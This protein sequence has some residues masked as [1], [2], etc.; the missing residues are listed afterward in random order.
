VA[1]P[2]RQPS[3][4]V[5][6]LGAMMGGVLEAC[7]L[8]PLDVVKT[9]LQLS[10]SSLSAL[11]RTMY[12]TE[13]PLSFYKG[14]TPFVTHLVTKYSVRWYFNEFYRGL[15]ADKNGKVSTA[16][17]FLAGTGAGITEAVLIVT[18]FE[19]IKTRLQQQ[20]GS[21]KSTFKYHG[22]IQTAQTIAK[23]EGVTALWKGNVPTMLRQGINQL[24]LFGTY[25][26]LKKLVFG[27]E[28]DSI[29]SSYQSLLL[30]IIAGALGPL[31]NNPID[32]AKTRLMAQISVP[33]VEPKY[34]G[35]FHCI[36]TVA[37]EE[38]FNALMRGCVMRIIRV[39][40]GMG[41]T[42]TTVEKFSEWFG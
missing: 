30:G 29:I 36:K 15:L 10:Q 22:M 14:L 28:R 35:T 39:A 40:P 16:N 33:G 17:G 4:M 21:D 38:G 12:R 1:T 9:R 25:D 7:S 37:S 13:G 42:F 41:I 31:F 5:K 32:V 2:K 23:E 11:V 18:P 8:Q 24:F 20:K 27:L 34:R 26:H 3:R 6:N 19:V